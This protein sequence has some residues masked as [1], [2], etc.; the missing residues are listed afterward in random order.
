MFDSG[1]GG[2]SVLREIR[3]ELPYEDLVYIADSAHA[4]YGDKEPE[5]VLTRAMALTEVLIAQR[6]KAIVVA[7]NTA[8]GAAVQRLRSLYA[9]PVIA[10]EPAVK[11][12]V[13]ISR[14]GVVG[15]LATS[16]T[17]ASHRFVELLGRVGGGAEVLVQP[18]PGLVERIEAGDLDGPQTRDL[19][20]RYL[21]PLLAQQADVIVLGCTHYPHVTPLITEIAGAGVLVMDASAAVARQVRRRLAEHALLRASTVPGRELFLTSGPPQLT[22]LV[23]RRLW[24]AAGTVRPLPQSPVSRVLDA[25]AR[26]PVKA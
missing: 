2:L 4:P 18:C 17:L 12:A 19:L 8:S 22:A 6:A 9:Q 21:R 16:H 1:V 24:P 26:A 23:I 3:R 20:Q 5:V 11:P 15:V 25:G 10:M 14:S 7:C 13:A